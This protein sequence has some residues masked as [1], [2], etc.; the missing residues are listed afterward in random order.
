MILTRRNRST[1]NKTCQSVSLL[2]I[3]PTRTDPRS[4]PGLSSE[5]LATSHL[6]QDTSSGTN[7]R[8]VTAADMTVGLKN[9]FIMSSGVAR[10]FAPG[11]SNHNGRT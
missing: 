7:L 1:R 9:C 10:S 6:S 11:A 5:R 2:T 8:E 4:N 3:N